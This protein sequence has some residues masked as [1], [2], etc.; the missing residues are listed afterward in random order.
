MP[1]KLH[2]AGIGVGVS[3]GAGM[4]A[5]MAR[6]GSPPLYRGVRAFREPVREVM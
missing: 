5:G 6:N 4:G 2:R 3:V 1:H